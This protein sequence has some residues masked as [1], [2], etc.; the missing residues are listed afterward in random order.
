MVAPLVLALIDPI[1]RLID[2]LIPDKEAAAKAKLDLLREEN[3]QELQALQLALQ[4]DTNQTEINKV[5]AAGG[6]L[7][8]AGWRPFIGW[9]CGGAFAYK[10]V[11]QPFLIFIMVA[12]HSS[13]NPALLPVIDWSEMSTVLLG[14]LGLSGMRTIE[15]IKGAE[16]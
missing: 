8:V 10:F 14:L 4:A 3:Q 13:F 6:N 15:K 16:K 5:E 9:T 1:S 11:L 7:F 12:A 2:K